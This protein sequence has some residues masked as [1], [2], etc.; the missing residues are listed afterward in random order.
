MS[1]HLSVKDQQLFISKT[2]GGIP[3]IVETLPHTRSVAASISVS[4]GS[5]D[6][7]FENNGI[8]HFLEHMIFRGT[9]T[10]TYKEV[11]EAIEDAGGYLNAFTMHELTAYYSLTMDETVPIGLTLLEDIFNNSM[12]APEYIELEKGVIKQEL[13]NAINE[14]ES[15]IRRLLMQTHFGDH[16]LAWPVLGREETIDSFMHDELQE[17]HL[18]HYC[19]PNLT[20]VAAGNVD[21]S[22]ILRWASDS[23]D[24]LANNGS[25]KERTAPR[26]H[27]SIDVYPRGGEHTYVGIGLPGVEAASDLSPVADVMC[28]I[29]SGASSSR[30]NHRIREEEGLVYGISMNQI[31][32]KDIG[33]IDTFFST[34]SE[35][36]EKVLELYAEELRK[37]KDEGLRPGEIDRAKRI[38]KGAILRIYGQPR[39]DMRSMVYSYC[40]TG[41]VR[42][43]D[44][45]IKRI[46]AVTEEQVMSFAQSQLKRSAM[47]AA[48]HAGKA[49]ADPVAVKAAGIDF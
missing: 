28:T 13:N 36:A 23:L 11:N 26:H 40:I 25:T 24:H 45:I 6:E 48:V 31:P 3:V 43:I 44:E 46:E 47:C 8:S 9:K 32:F 21:P 34:T 22:S 33:T 10:R 20:V 17:Y 14:P 4:V 49:Q 5:R 27:S 15:Y 37:F 19:P 41:R 1:N 7:S 42:T 2:P 35:R 29:L 12:M 38:I 18:K 39:D 30:L 16:P